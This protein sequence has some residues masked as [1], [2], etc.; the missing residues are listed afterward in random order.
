M[1]LGAHVSIAGG[2]D[3]AVLRGLEFGCDAI[4]IFTKNNNQWRAAPLKKDVVERFRANLA[5]SGMCPVV[6][7]TSYL[8]NLGTSAKRLW[9]KSC[10]SFET[11]LGR[12]EMLGVPFLVTHPGSHTGAGT[13]QGLRNVAD[14]LN[15]V[16][17][18][19]KG[20][21]VV[22]LVEHMA[23]QGTNL[24]CDFD[25]V[26][27]LFD[28][29]KDKERIGVCLDTCHLFASGCDYRSPE[30]YEALMREIDRTLGLDWVKCVHLND[31]KTPLGSRVDRHEH[32]G[33]GK[34]GRLG[35]QLF[36]TDP[37][38]KQTPG[39]IETPTDGSGK[40][41]RRN[42]RVLRRLASKPRPGFQ[43][44]RTSQ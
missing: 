6:A 27:Q 10:K 14:A 5:D 33:K 31:S 38:F 26:R 8:I 7:H 41:E 25:Q 4:Q 32:I 24:C 20:Y 13:D 9:N 17:G 34:I 44:S 40:D 21:R 35:F 16:H 11:E 36:L 22:T 23:G 29:V 39:L 28:M 42:L 3:L 30:K 37:R 18:R 15:L 1:R 12:C 2:A 19:T 43:P